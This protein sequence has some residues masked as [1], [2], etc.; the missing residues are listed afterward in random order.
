MNIC[1]PMLVIIMPI[2]MISIF[3]SLTNICVYYHL[4]PVEISIFRFIVTNRANY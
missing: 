3:S 4:E 2:R 1:I